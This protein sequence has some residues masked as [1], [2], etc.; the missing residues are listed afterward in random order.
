MFALLTVYSSV[1]FYSEFTTHKWMV[2]ISKIVMAHHLHPL[3]VRGSLR[4]S[5][6]VY[7]VLYLIQ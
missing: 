7:D 4:E 6:L 3:A 5:Y 1:G 2:G